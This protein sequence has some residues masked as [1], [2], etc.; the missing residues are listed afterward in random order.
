[1]KQKSGHHL[2]LLIDYLQMNPKQFSESLGEKSP[3]KIYNILNGIN[4]VSKPL[5]KTIAQT[6]QEIDYSWLISGEGSMHKGITKEEM[7]L[8]C[9][10]REMNELMDENKKLSDENKQLLREHRELSKE[11][12]KLRLELDKLKEIMYNTKNM[13]ATEDS[14]ASG[15]A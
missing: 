3:T 9:S 13:V 11:N 14:D 12:R 4:G 5:A 2:Q 10:D 15:A 7:E 6:Y 1:M 8:I